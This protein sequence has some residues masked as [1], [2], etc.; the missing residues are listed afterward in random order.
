MATLRP[1][2]GIRPLAR[3]AQRVAS[4]PYDVVDTKEARQEAAGNP[5]SF[6]HVV[7]PEI[8]FPDGHDPYDAAVYRKGKENFDRLL[9]GGV[10]TQDPAPCYY[11]YALTKDGRTQHGIVGCA[12]VDDYFDD[13]IRKHEL[14][15]PDKEE[16]RKNHVRVSNLHY[17]P[18]FFAYP[19]HAGLDRL[20]SQ[21]TAAEPVVDFTADDGIRH[22]F[23]VLDDAGDIAAVTEAFAGIPHTY[24]ADG[25]HRTAA[26]ALVGRE[27]AAANPA[28]RGDE[29]YNFFL[30][31]HFPD[32]ELRIMDY[33]RVIRDLNGLSPEAFLEALRRRFAVEKHGPEAYRP[34]KLHELSLYLGG[35]W[36]ALT[37]N[38]GTFDDSDPIRALD[39]T[40]LSEQVLAPLLGITDLRNDKRIDFVGGLRGLGE[41][42][43]RVDSGEMKAAF[44]LYPVSMQ[45]LIAIADSGRIMPPKTT[46]FEPKLRSG[47]V[48]HSLD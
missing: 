28:H 33:N 48:V 15:R 31:V 7:K 2:R 41:L 47:L 46:W 35:N 43:R 13:V 25:H 38:P 14:T 19:R 10:F 18:V 36:Y 20:V 1:F 9:A 39:V 34:S 30:A 11:L 40:V 3:W 42:K 17:E 44:A 23:W 45:Q 8:D 21:R 22:A 12:A 29:E 6:F 32:H 5:Q 26:A 4:R 16:D 27:R 24:V 37:A